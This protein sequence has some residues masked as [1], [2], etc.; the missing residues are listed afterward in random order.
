MHSTF[1]I[2]DFTV[3][4]SSQAPL[5]CLPVYSSRKIPETKEEERERIAKKLAE[6]KKV[7]SMPT[8]AKVGTI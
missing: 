3:F 8:T 1:N 5:S 7:E 4:V 6:S 2:Q